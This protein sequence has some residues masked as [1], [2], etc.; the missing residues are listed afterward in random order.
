MIERKFTAYPLFVKDPNFSIWARE[1]NLCNADTA[2]WTGKYARMYGVFEVNGKRYSFMGKSGLQPAEQTDLNV[3]AFSTDYRFVA[4]GC[5][6]EVRFL[7]PLPLNDLEVMSCPC[8]YFA[9]KVTAPKG[10]KTAV[11]LFVSDEI[12]YE[13]KAEVTFLN[14]AR[15]GMKN[16]VLGLERQLPLSNTKDVAVADWGYYY[17]TAETAGV[18]TQ[19]HFKEFAGGG[20]LT[21]ADKG[22]QELLAY[23]MADGEGTYEGKFVLSY[24]DTVSIFYFG[25]WLRGYWFRNGKTI[26]DAIDFSIGHYHDI[27]PVLDSFDRKLIKDSERY[28][29][30]YLTLL[31]A[32]LRQSIAAH[33]LVES[34][35]GEVLFLS[36]ECNSNGCIATLD[37]TYPSL[38]LFLLYNPALVKGMMLPIIRTAKGEA[39]RRYAF[40]PHDAGRYPYCSGQV[41]GE[42][43]D[44]PKHRKTHTVYSN[45][46]LLPADRDNYLAQKHMPVEEC[47]NALIV[48]DALLRHGETKFV[49]ENFSLLNCWA[50]YLAEK[51]VVPEN[52][53]CTD[54]FTGMLD[55]NVNLAIK[56]A[57]GLRAFSD[58]CERLH[59]DGAEKYKKKAEEFA[60]AI[61]ALERDGVLPLTFDYALSP[62]SLKYNL[63]FDKLFGFG[64]FS[65]EVYKKEV[66]YYLAHCNRYGVPLDERSTISKTDWLIWTAALTGDREKSGKFVDMID[67]FMKETK[68]REPF[69][70]WY[71]AASGE[72]MKFRNRA[73]QG[74]VFALLYRDRILSENM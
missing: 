53:L 54:D 69:P 12:C 6:L 48:M 25:D 55:K 8:C 24:D 47:G 17:L 15:K 60:S 26:F 31:R 1:E 16:A 59:R 34:P 36:K 14:I 18:T 22:E 32:A 29:E 74:A 7:S 4:D 35:Q 40:A 41:Y 64:L 44:Y 63:Y 58:I 62:Y 51:G 39:W 70:D 45:T 5:T 56:S 46:Y 21:D 28:G 13:N 20:A 42:L 65:Q 30:G 10:T 73:V 72:C 68:Q 19:T 27:L 23:A 52:Q 38:P 11:Y 33:K 71:D 49:S 3:T 61:L 66:D 2:F 50:D 67:L 37:I 9:Y 43:D 57:V